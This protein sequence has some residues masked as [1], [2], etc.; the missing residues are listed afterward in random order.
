[1]IKTKMYVSV[2]GILIKL[3]AIP[4]ISYLFSFYIKLQVYLY[5]KIMTILNVNLMIALSN[6]E[7]K[8][9]LIS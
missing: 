7:N 9:C 5:S 1:M 2:K 3:I 4:K 6:L 8:V